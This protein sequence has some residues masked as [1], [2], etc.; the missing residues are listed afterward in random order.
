MLHNVSDLS[1]LASLD[2]N[3]WGDVGIRGFF[4]ELVKRIFLKLLV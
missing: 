3:I 1:G 2:E 4:A